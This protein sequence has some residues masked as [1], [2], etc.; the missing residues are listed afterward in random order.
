[1]RGGGQR[2]G[3]VH[4]PFAQSPLTAHPRPSGSTEERFA[5]LSGISDASPRP[6]TSALLEP[7]GSRARLRVFRGT[8]GELGRPR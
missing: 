7:S 1:M 4:R 6:L 3:R 2:A 5:Y 8:P